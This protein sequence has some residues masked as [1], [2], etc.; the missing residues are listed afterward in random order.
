MKI[1]L[2][3]LC[4]FSM[5]PAAPE[6]IETIL[7]EGDRIISPPH[8]RGIFQLT[9]ISQ[10]RDI[11]V[12]KAEAYQKKV[13]EVQENRIFLFQFPPSIKGTGLLIHSFFDDTDNRMWIY[14]PVVKRIKRIALETSGGGHF[15]GSDFTYSDLISRSSE[16][17]NYELHGEEALLGEECY[18]IKAE[19][20]TREIRQ[21]MGYL[22]TVNYYR[23]KDFML[24]GIDYY[25]LAGDLLKTYRVYNV[26]ML[27]G[28]LYPSE[29]VMQNVQNG[30]SSK[31]EF[32]ELVVEDIPDE[33]FTHFYLKEGHK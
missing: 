25:D 18:L 13:S 30:H 12:V 17:Y 9:L 15:M 21:N 28:F 29:V 7:K 8:I 20:K 19:G 2:I 1:I 24:T 16:E 31:I 6:D 33:Y 11:R 10:N 22:Y 27:K 32:S 23:K 5:I 4:L 14:L 26:E 3:A